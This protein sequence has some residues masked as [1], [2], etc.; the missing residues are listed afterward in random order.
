MKEITKII[1]LLMLMFGTVSAQQRGI[2]GDNWLNNWTQFNPK[3]VD[4]GES[5]HILTGN[6]TEDTKLLKK[7]VYQL[8]GDV[9]VTNNAKLSIEPG[10]VIMADAETRASLTITKGAKIVAEGL[11][12]DPI[13]FTSNKSYKKAGDWRGIILLGDAPTNK[14]GNTSSI[15]SFYSNM[16]PENYENTNFGG[17]NPKSN[18]G[19]LKYVRI[20]YAGAVKKVKN[21]DASNAILLAGI[22]NETIINNVMVSYSA[23]NSFNVIGG[24]VNL[25]KI[26]SFKS[27]G[28][29]YK[30]NYGAQCNLSNGLAIRSPYTSNGV[31]S[32]CMKVVSYDKKGDVDFS[33]KGT[34]I[35]A[36][37][38]TFLTDTETLDSDIK[39][40]L[41]KESIYI[42]EN[43]LFEIG[44]SVISGFSPAVLLNENILING[45]NLAK[46]QFS[47]MYFNNCNGNIFRDYNSNNE[48]LENWYGN[49]AFFNVYSK[50]EHSEIFVDIKNRKKPDYRLRINE[51]VAMNNL[52]GN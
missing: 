18:S 7:N 23:G 29:D 43:T 3:T 37:N 25:E 9:F 1:G 14:L 44:K 15:S 35:I 45:E 41:V 32:R 6:I 8:L 46:L 38:V 39:L 33:K 28:T 27:A 19:I 50:S 11:L 16:K 10:T 36:N 52:G 42:G 40:G 22:G 47:K 2:E 49:D 34:A 24:E 26:V 30:F 51:I 17:S 4:Y 21:P 48:D 13:V 5:S 20:E 31:D 12:T